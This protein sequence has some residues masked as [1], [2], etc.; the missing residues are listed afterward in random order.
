MLVNYWWEH[1]SGA[2][3][4]AMIHAIGAVRD[5]PAAEKAAWR[6]WFDH[7]IFAPD[8]ADAADHLPEAARG[9][10]GPPSAARSNRIRQ[11]LAGVLGQA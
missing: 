1:R 9:I 2:A 4:V 11:F 7:F 5:L 3:F 6:T 10:L 8:A